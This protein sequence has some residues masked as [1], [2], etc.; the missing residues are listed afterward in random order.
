MACYGPETVSRGN[1][2][3]D[4]N[5][6]R[7]AP[8]MASTPVSSARWMTG[9][10]FGEWLVGI[11]LGD[12]SGLLGLVVGVW[13]RAADVPEHRGSVPL[14]SEEAE[15]LAGGDRRGTLPPPPIL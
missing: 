8:T 7:A 5:Q 6:A 11:I 4:D 15:V 1:V 12:P 9:A 14:A 13:V 3:H 10:K 2:D